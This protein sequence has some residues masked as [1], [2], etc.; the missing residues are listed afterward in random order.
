MFFSS[1]NNYPFI[2]AELSGNHNGN[3]E[4]MFKLI[5]EAKKCNADA[6]KIQTYSPDTITLNS[7]NKDF[8]ITKG[9]WAGKTL[10]D[11]YK[12]AH[13]PYEWH[14]DIFDYAKKL[15]MKIFSSPFS[16]FDTDFLENLGCEAYKIASFEVT[17]LPLIKHIANKKK[18]ILLSTGMATFQEITTAVNL[19]KSISKN[20]F[21][22]LHCVSGYPSFPSEANLN[23]MLLLSKKYKCKVGLSDHCLDNT[24]AMLATSMG[25]KIIEKHMILERSSGGVDSGFSLEPNEF[26]QL[27]NLVKDSALIMGT[28][29]PEFQKTELLQR[30]LR[31]SIYASAEIDKNQIFTPHNIKVIRPG[32]GLDPKYYEQLIGKKSLRKIE[33]GAPL[34]LNYIDGVFEDNV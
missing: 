32:Y 4:N 3:I 28:S 20:E 23:R 15:N 26:Q 18:P 34:K 22:M 13:T 29:T 19:I 1:N 6:V 7:T 21:A 2:I 8:L 25:A 27:V 5:D 31:R 16:E 9:P 12:E 17:H 33:S 30:P 11:L 10:Y 24:V 14:K